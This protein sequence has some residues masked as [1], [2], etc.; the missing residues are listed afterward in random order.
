MNDSRHSSAAGRDATPPLPPWPDC[1]VFCI[2][3]YA[4]EAGT[5]CGWR[6]R[7]H[8]ARKVTSDGKPRCP[9]C[10]GPTLLGL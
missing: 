4:G 8:D 1:E 7:W 5:P 3:S 6:G 2:Q 10:G 9:R